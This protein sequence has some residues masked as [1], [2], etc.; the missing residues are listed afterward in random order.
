MPS[1]KERRQRQDI[2]M[3][4]EVTRADQKIHACGLV[5]QAVLPDRKLAA[6]SRRNRFPT[7]NKTPRRFLASYKPDRERPNL[8][9]YRMRK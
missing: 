5:E 7:A 6:E 9:E 2:K 3:G 1:D 8:I 4:K